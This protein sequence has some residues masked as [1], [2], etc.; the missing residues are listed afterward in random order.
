MVAHHVA[1]QHAGA[2]DA[3]SQYKE[4]ATLTLARQLFFGA[5]C[6]ST[7]MNVPDWSTREDVDEWCEGEEVQGGCGGKMRLHSNSRSLGDAEGRRGEHKRK[8]LYN[9]Q[10]KKHQE[11]SQRIRVKRGIVTKCW[12]WL[13]TGTVRKPTSMTDPTDLSAMTPESSPS[14]SRLMRGRM[15][16]TS[17]AG[18]SC[19]HRQQ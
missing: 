17:A 15:R 7:L 16:E 11:C 18:R 4:R 9:V 2:L 14:A 6:F 5:Y 12:K 10:L 8:S 13:N 3:E 1:I 19:K